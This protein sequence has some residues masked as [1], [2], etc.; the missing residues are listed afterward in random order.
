MT[1]GQTDRI[2]GL[3]ALLEIDG[4]TIAADTGEIFRAL[5]QDIPQIP[6]PMQPIARAKVPVYVTVSALSKQAIDA[7]GIQVSAPADPRAM[8]V[9]TEPDYGTM[10]VLRYDESRGDAL[11]LEW[12][13]EAQRQ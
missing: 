2:T 5:I 13:C 4:R 7:M 9:F 10:T 1:T 6:D 12:T 8:K 3:L 11:M